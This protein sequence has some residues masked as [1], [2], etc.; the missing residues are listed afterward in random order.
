MHNN[1]YEI[2]EGRCKLKFGKFKR[3]FLLDVP[4]WYLDFMIN[5]WKKDCDD[6]AMADFIEIMEDTVSGV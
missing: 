1:F 5:Y 4:L 6:E 3:E 2:I